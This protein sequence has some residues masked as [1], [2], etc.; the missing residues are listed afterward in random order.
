MI[1]GMKFNKS[2]G[3]SNTTHRYKLG[4]GWLESSPAERDLGV[5]VGSRL[6]VS[7]QCAL[8]ANR[9]NA[10]L[11]CTKHS[12]TGRSK[13]GIIPLHSVLVRPHPEYCV[14][15]WGTQFKK[16]LKVLECVQRR[17]TKLVKGLEGRSFKERLKS[18]GLPGLEKRKVRANLIALYSFLR[19][20]S[21][22][23]GAE[24]FSLGIQ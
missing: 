6:S 21:R 16:I 10:N 1:N 19:R 7:W 15:F 18:L 11:G 20:G 24:L 2:K 12:I 17:A 14:Q 8:A 22:E 9:A 3:Q 5:L 23:R 13:E 4:E